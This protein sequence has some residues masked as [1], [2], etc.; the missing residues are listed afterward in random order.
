[1]EVT[2]ACYIVILQVKKISFIKGLIDMDQKLAAL[3]I[4]TVEFGS[5]DLVPLDQKASISLRS[6]W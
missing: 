6:L 3:P 1:M 4:Y 2:A 5:W